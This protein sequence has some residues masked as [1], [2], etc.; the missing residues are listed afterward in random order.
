MDS[1][2]LFCPIYNHCLS[3]YDLLV[4]VINILFVI[5]RWLAHWGKE[6]C[7]ASHRS[8]KEPVNYS[9]CII[10]IISNYYYSYNLM[11][12]I[13]FVVNQVWPSSS[14]QCWVEC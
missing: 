5:M 14:R 12:I 8:T 3:C 6:E 10:K 13:S 11:Y 1:S 9:L 4:S 7:C 2:V